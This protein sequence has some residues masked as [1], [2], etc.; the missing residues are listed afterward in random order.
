[1]TRT[2]AIAHPL[3]P[4]PFERKEEQGEKREFINKW[5]GKQK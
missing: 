1:V 4:A 2:I 3:F 5:F